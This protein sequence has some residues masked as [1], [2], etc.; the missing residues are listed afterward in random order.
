MQKFR[1]AGWKPLPGYQ[2]RYLYFLDPT[3]RQR[4]TVPI[5]PFSRIAEMGAC[6]YRGKPRAGS[7]ASGTT[8]FQSV[9]GGATP[10]PALP[11]NERRSDG[12]T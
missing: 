7:A 10:T 3:A 4:L 9:R 6:M 8:D 1:D 2:L 12:T 5:L 11:H